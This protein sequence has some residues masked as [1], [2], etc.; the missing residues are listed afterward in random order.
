MEYLKDRVIVAR[1]GATADKAEK[2]GWGQT[3]EKL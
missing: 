3:G 2:T 1:K